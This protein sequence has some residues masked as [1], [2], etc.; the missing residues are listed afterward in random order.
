LV[1]GENEIWAGAVERLGWGGLG[2]GRETDGRLVLLSAPL[3]LFPGEE[4]TAKLTRQVRHSEG[5]VLAW[6][7]ADARRVEPACPNARECGGCTLWGAGSYTGELKRLMAAD[8]LAR[9][10]LAAPEDWQ[11][12]PAP[13]TARRQRIQLHWDGTAL[14]YY[15][16]SSHRLIPVQACPAAD[17]LVQSAIPALAQALSRG[18]LPN[19]EARWELA[20]GTPSEVVVAASNA[21]LGRSWALLGGAWCEPAPALEHH[22]FGRRLVQSPGAFFQAC[23][24]WAAEALAGVLEGWAVSGAELYD[25]YGGGGLFSRLL[26]GRFKHYTLVENGALAVADAQANLVGQPSEIIEQSVE[27]WLKPKLGAP[28]DTLILDPPRAGLGRKLC[29]VLATARAGRIVLCGCDGAA[30]CR[31]VGFLAPR[32]RL[33]RLAMLDLFPNTPQVECVGE[34]VPAE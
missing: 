25:L 29:S 4:V 2:L 18:K 23:A 14:G 30:F 9:Q 19:G 13:A 16:C 21:V 11:W 34:L 15:A 6:R 26:E 12:L 17:E 8:L 1:T 31:D 3:A 32:W 7:A 24:A 5:E 28:G 22:L 20:T 10:L 27:R 33:N